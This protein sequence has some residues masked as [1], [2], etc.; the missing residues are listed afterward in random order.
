VWRVELYALS[1][2]LFRRRRLVDEGPSGEHRHVQ[3]VESEK[4]S[5]ARDER[6]GLG[7]EGERDEVVVFGVGV[8][9]G[10]FSGSST[11]TAAAPSSVTKP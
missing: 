8:T 6:V 10:R 5:V 3:L 11:V 1:V 7:G 9:A 4:V 2:V